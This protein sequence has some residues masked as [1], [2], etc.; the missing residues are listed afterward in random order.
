LKIK[1]E[2]IKIMGDRIPNE[3]GSCIKGLIFAGDRF[4]C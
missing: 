4:R 3:L 2:N 1:E